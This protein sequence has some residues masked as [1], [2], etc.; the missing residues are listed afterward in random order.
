MGDG[1]GA[2]NSQSNNETGTRKQEAETSKQLTEHWTWN[3]ET[4]TCKQ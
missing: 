2:I 1:V 4:G 3:W